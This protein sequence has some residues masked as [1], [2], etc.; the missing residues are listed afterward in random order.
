MPRKKGRK[1]AYLTAGIVVVSISIVL[2]WSWH[3]I[4]GYRVEP[5][6]HIVEQAF[7]EERSDIM[8]EVSGQVV[9]TVRP[10][11]GNE[12]YQ[13]FQM[14]MPNGQLLLVVHDAGTG[15][16]IPLKPHDEV[17]V[18]GNYQWTELGGT[19]YGTQR[20]SSM[21]RLHGWIEH[22]GKKYQ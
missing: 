10:V 3:S 6:M 18:R 9:R 7:Y 1:P 17:K 16:R 21:K 20:D 22:Q 15:E 11:R 14:R 5:G 13:E 2:G 4:P 19:I 8:V 12:S